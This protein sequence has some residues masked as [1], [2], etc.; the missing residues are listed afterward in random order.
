[1]KKAYDVIVIGGGIAGIAASLSAARENK[2]VLLI[3]SSFQ[4][5]GLATSGLI[6]WYEPLCNG[7]GTQ[8]IYGN[9]LELLKLASEYGATLDD[10]WLKEGKGEGR[11][12]TFFNHNIFATA[13]TCLLHNEGV[14][15]AFDSLFTN[16]NIENKKI[17]SVKI[18]TIEK[19][20][21]IECDYVVDASGTAKVYSC[22]NLPLRQGKNYLS[23]YVH[24]AGDINSNQYLRHWDIYGANMSGNGQPLDFPLLVGN[25]F[26]DVNDYIIKSHEVFYQEV[27]N[28]NRGKDITSIPHMPQFRMICS[29]IGEKTID[30]TYKNKHF[31]DSIATFG[32]FLEPGNTFEIPY[33]SLYNKDITNLFAV[34]RIISSSEQG[35]DAIRVIP[36][37]AL[38]GEIVAE[39]INLL[40]K[41][42][43]ENH[44]LNKTLLKQ[45]INNKEKNYD[46]R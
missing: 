5:G 28:N 18:Q 10:N 26:K 29:I 39:A 30:N 23:F 34:G 9:A 37:A 35:W 1:M 44:K 45:I 21:T 40:I 14:D 8:L 13:L 32:Y 6:N 7:K 38:S 17:K 19:E 15:L 16:V 11:F 43:L 24:K 42:K 27:K 33:E 41:D 20:E 3:E 25:T 4:L 31:N 36:V 2:N 46:L 22:C 12:A